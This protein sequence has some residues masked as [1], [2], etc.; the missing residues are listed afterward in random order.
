MMSFNPSCQLCVLLSY[1]CL[2]PTQVC[3]LA[4]KLLRTGNIDTETHGTNTKNDEVQLYNERLMCTGFIGVKKMQVTNL[5]R[6]QN[7]V[8]E[9][10]RVKLFREDIK[11]CVLH[12]TESAGRCVYVRSSQLPVYFQIYLS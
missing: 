5:G 2:L 10:W 7:C 12:I 6:Q 11:S 9:Q 1:P 8:A 3:H 4:Q